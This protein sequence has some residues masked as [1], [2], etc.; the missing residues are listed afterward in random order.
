M[1]FLTNKRGFSLVEL[2]TVIAIIAIL[3]SIIFPVMSMVGNRARMNKCMTQMHQIGLAVQIFKQDNRKYPDVLGVE[4]MRNGGNVVPMDQPVPS[5]SPQVVG[6]FP[7]Y[8]K[9][10]KLYHC[11][12]SKFIDTTQIIGANAAYD[13]LGTGAGIEAY[14]YNSYD[15]MIYGGT[16]IRQ[17]YTKAWAASP[18]DVAAQGPGAPGDPQRDYE[19]QLKFKTPPDDTVVTWCSWHE[20]YSG[21]GTNLT[22]T[23]KAPTL[24]LDGH[25]DVLS[26]PE[27]ETQRWRVLPKKE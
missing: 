16:D 20:V 21:S 11:P 4:V 6:L 5:A 3:A 17:H 25:V 1:R 10:A 23:G 13:P 8:V 2:L 22:V 9:S 24:F 15:F 27:V 12:N 14:T 7:E 18:G 26:A 19:R